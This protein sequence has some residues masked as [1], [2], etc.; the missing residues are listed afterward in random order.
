MIKITSLISVLCLFVCLLPSCGYS[1]NN[2][3]FEIKK[4]FEWDTSAGFVFYYFQGNATYAFLQT[5]GYYVVLRYDDKKMNIIKTNSKEYSRFD[6]VGS[7][8]DDFIDEGQQIGIYGSE[9]IIKI[10][11]NLSVNLNARASGK[12]V[13][14]IMEN[15]NKYEIKDCFYIDGLSDIVFVDHMNLKV[16]FRAEVKGETGIAVVDIKQKIANLIIKE[17]DNRRHFGDQYSSPVRIPNTEFLLFYQ[18]RMYE[19]FTNIFIMEI[20]EWKAEI[21]QQKANVKLYPQAKKYFINGPANIRN[22]PKGKIF[23]TID[24]HTEVLVLNNDGDWYEVLYANIRG[25]TYKDNLR[26]NEVTENED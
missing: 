2:K 18:T 10:Q 22:T 19:S 26:L 13:I 24:H 12:K 21:E 6:V 11:D 9:N 17:E 8:L 14:E 4:I 25:W 1:E 20:P 3:I 23:A 5:G 7:I 15:E 16:Y